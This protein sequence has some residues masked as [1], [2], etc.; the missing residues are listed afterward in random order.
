MKVA[1]V[2]AVGIVLLVS[3]HARGQSLTLVPSGD[4]DLI[5]ESGAFAGVLEL[6]WRGWAP[7]KVVEALSFRSGHLAVIVKQPT[8]QSL[9]LS[10]FQYSDWVPRQV[11]EMQPGD[12]LRIPILLVKANRNYIFQ[13]LG[14]YEISARM[15]FS[16]EIA[17]DINRIEIE[18]RPVT[19]EVGKGSSGRDEFRR[20]CNRRDLFVAFSYPELTRGWRPGEHGLGEYERELAKVFV[21][22]G[23]TEAVNSV[24]H[25]KTE[26]NTKM[27]S[28]VEQAQSVARKYGV[29]E[30]MWTW[31]R[32]SLE[33]KIAQ[34]KHGDSQV[35]VGDGY[36]FE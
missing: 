14:R 20:M 36:Y 10:R 29:G 8:G 33:G 24:M 25:G 12:V 34:K 4:Q 30:E 32:G 7:M 26:L 2:L 16:A 19:I 11:I 15:S 31:I 1:R 5:P 3:A 13:E 27:A 21:L 6:E 9:F 28:G 35:V 23:M 17:G 18:S 22:G